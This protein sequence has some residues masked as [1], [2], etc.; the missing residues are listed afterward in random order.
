MSCGTI[1]RGSSADCD[2]LPPGGTNARLILFNFD[3]IEGFDEDSDNNITDITLKQGATGYE[4]L[5]FRNDGKTSEEVVKLE[6][7]SP[8]FKHNVG[9]VVY[10]TTQVQKN[11]VEDTARGRSVRVG[12]EEGSANIAREG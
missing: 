10:E 2:S 9:L 6:M 5:G 3:D 11:S 4:F 7:G 12:E 8:K 1:T